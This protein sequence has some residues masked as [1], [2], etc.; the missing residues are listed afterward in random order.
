MYLYSPSA[1]MKKYPPE[2]NSGEFSHPHPHPHHPF[3]FPV[4]SP[5]SIFISTLSLH[6][7]ITPVTLARSRRS[8][9][10]VRQLGKE[11]APKVENLT[12]EFLKEMYWSM[13]MVSSGLSLPSTQRG[14]GDPFGHLHTT[15]TYQ[16]EQPG[17]ICFYHLKKLVSGNIRHA[18]ESHFHSFCCQLHRHL[19]FGFPT[20]LP[21]GKKIDGLFSSPPVLQ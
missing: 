15:P 4:P 11:K 13:A 16:Q 20:H 7:L 21:P 8:K 9:S 18:G 17:I 10:M 1:H 12:T 5:L 6:F 19:G 3:P 14:G 2:G